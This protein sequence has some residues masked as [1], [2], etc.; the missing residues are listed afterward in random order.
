MDV[1]GAARK[2]YAGIVDGNARKK[3]HQLESP[4]EGWLATFRRALGMSQADVA[5]RLGVGRASVQQAERRETDGAITLDKMDKIA[6]AMGGRLVYA[7]VPG[8]SPK[9]KVSDMID[10]QARAKASAL[11][12][13]ANIQ[14]ALENQAL[15]KERNREKVEELAAEIARTMPR[16]FWR[17]NDGE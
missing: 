9:Q 11:N 7:I 16:G 4:V 5:T 12:R 6:S 15:S 10:D 8:G 14:M 3:A 1:K 17:T 13:Y 2:Q